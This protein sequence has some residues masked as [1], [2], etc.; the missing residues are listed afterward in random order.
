VGFSDVGYS[1]SKAALEETCFGKEEKCWPFR[2]FFRTP[3]VLA[4]EGSWC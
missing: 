2:E 4:V 3:P 1:T